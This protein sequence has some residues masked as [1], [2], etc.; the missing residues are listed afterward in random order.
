MHLFCL[1][2]PRARGLLLLFVV[3][4]FVV[5]YSR[6]KLKYYRLVVTANE[7]GVKYLS[8]LAVVTAMV[9]DGVIVVG[10]LIVVIVQRGF[11]VC[12]VGFI[13]QFGARS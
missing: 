7:T 2:C 13:R 12:F 8:L 1:P 9:W 10:V 5:V 3:V 11:A 6:W 4:V